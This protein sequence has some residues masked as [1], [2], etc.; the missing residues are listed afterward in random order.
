[1][2]NCNLVH[3]PVKV[4]VHLQKGTNIPKVNVS[5][6]HSVIGYL[7]FVAMMSKI[8]INYI[9]YYVYKYM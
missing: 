2:E 1:M 3:A 8:Y 7:L 4:R 9:V 6:F 5:A